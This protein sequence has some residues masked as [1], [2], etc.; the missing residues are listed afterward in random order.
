MIYETFFEDIF[1]DHIKK[2]TL[3]ERK[4]IFS[5]IKLLKNNPAH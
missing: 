3:P 2:F 5:K 4:L 1:L